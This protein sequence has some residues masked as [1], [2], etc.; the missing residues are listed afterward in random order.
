MA[1]EPGIG[2]RGRVVNSECVRKVARK[3]IPF[4][5]GSALALVT[6]TKVDLL[7]V[8]YRDMHNA[9]HGAVFLLPKTGADSAQAAFGSISTAE[10]VEQPTPTCGGGQVHSSTLKIMTIT[11]EGVLVPAE[12]KVLLYEQLVR[13]LTDEAGYEHIIR[14]GDTSSAAACPELNLSITLEAFNKGNAV[15]RASSGLLGMFVG[16]TS[17]K[18]HMTLQDASGQNVIDKEL[19]KSE[20][21]DS[22]NLDVADDIAKN[23]PGTLKKQR[24][25]DAKARTTAG[26]KRPMD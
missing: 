18:F 15:F 20:R 17:L 16:T 12:Y 24:K 22:E 7:T 19:K 21:G 11:S 4:G 9:Y 8:E 3:A 14:D 5:G 26:A 23:V 6:Q 25:E 13:R 2:A 1:A 10:E